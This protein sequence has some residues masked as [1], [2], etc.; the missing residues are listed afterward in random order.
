MSSELRAA[1]A[2][3]N[4]KFM[5]TF[6][7]GDAAGIARLYTAGGQ[8][9]PA[10]SDFVTGSAAIAQFWVGAIGMGIKSAHLETVELEDHGDTVVEVGKYSLGGEGGQAVDQG[11]YLVVWKMEG[12]EWKLHR[13]IWTSSMPA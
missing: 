12:G 4:Q 5:D 11:K 1:I 7:R 8:L 3:A 6:A 13:D 10:N 2:A 9:L